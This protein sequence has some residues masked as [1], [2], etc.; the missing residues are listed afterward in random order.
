MQGLDLDLAQGLDLDLSFYLGAHGLASLSPSMNWRKIRWH[1][2]D[3]SVLVPV[4][5]D[6]DLNAFSCVPFVMSLSSDSCAH[7]PDPDL[8][9]C[10]LVSI[11]LDLDLNVLCSLAL[12]SD[13]LVTV[14]WSLCRHP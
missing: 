4:D 3:Q 12:V 14:L 5:L 13:P 7:I 10:V 8:H 2:A 9:H 1:G 11:D 6:L